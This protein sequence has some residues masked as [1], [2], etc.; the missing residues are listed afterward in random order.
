M[1][2][3]FFQSQIHILVQR[4]VYLHFLVFAN[5][6]QIGMNSIYLQQLIEVLKEQSQHYCLMLLYNVNYLA[7][8]MYNYLNSSMKYQKMSEFLMN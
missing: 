8:D 4:C 5:A 2:I 7:L 6:L 3:N 1:Q